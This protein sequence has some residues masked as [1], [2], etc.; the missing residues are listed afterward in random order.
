MPNLIPATALFL[1]FALSCFFYGIA[2]NL[3]FLW[4][5]TLVPVALWCVAGPSRVATLFREQPTVGISCVVVLACIVTNHLFFSI[6]ADTSFAPGWIVACLPLFALVCLLYPDAR[7][8]SAIAWLVFLFA[9]ISVWEFVS[10]GQRAHAPFF[11]PNNYVTLLYLAWLPW[12]LVRLGAIRQSETDT[13]VSNPM[14][15]V[16]TVGVSFVV[17]LAMLATYSRFGWAVLVG[18]AF[19]IGFLCWRKGFSAVPAAIVVCAIA[20]AAGTFWLLSYD[21]SPSFG[22]AVLPPQAEAGMPSEGHAI[23]AADAEILP[24]SRW[25]MLES[26]WRMFQ[27]H[28]GVGGIGLFGFALL[29]PMFRSPGEQETAGQF[30]HNDYVQL[31]LEGGVWLALPMLV[32][33]GLVAYRCARHLLSAEA[34]DQRIAFLI[35]IGVAMAHALVNFVFY[36]LPL[37]LLLG[38]LVANGFA[39][40]S[41]NDSS[42]VP[43]RRAWSG[44]TWVLISGVLL[45]NSAW[46]ALD[47]MTYGVF[48]NHRYLPFVSEIRSTP[49]SLLD[50]AQMSQALNG[51]RGIPVLG[52][53]KLLDVQ[54]GTQ[55]DE[56][57]LARINGT[58][59]QAVD[60][61]P[62]NPLALTSYYD[63]LI[64]HPQWVG[65]GARAEPALL[66]REAARLQPLD[67]HTFALNVDQAVLAGDTEGAGRRVA[68]LVRWCELLLRQKRVEFENLLTRLEASRIVGSSPALLR[69]ITACERSAASIDQD[70]RKPTA[71]MRWIR[72]GVT[73]PAEKRAPEVQK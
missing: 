9:F 72:D 52:E 37:C 6:S 70:G 32:F 14:A 62:W 57:Q 29:Y 8:F 17:S 41:A 67:L 2:F 12:V 68:E 45:L 23:A 33:V 53:A 35:A 7:V 43:G 73:E 44:L 51:D 27:T 26:A 5:V 71:L 66:L 24:G 48:S 42:A 22:A 36:I 39:R 58:Y 63:F 46:L 15:T 4:L 13:T 30:V 11:E 59:Q 28:G 3:S 40:Q 60:R 25:L 69:Q 47:V 56:A 64:R 61:D 1:A 54:V 10:A 21:P 55:P 49:E 50:F 20:A 65:S 18:A 19:L 38:V 34:W 16:V 31:A